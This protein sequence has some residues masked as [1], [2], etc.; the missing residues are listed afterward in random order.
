[1]FL[2][3]VIKRSLWYTFSNLMAYVQQSYHHQMLRCTIVHS[4]AVA[5]V[6]SVNFDKIVRFAFAL[7]KNFIWI[8]MLQQRM[9]NSIFGVPWAKKRHRAFTVARHSNILSFVVVV[10]NA[11]QQTN[12]F[13]LIHSIFRNLFSNEKLSFWNYFTL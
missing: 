3:D 10:K 1:M 5:L 2:Y 12:N 8:S 11:M 7:N 4:V 9:F 6:C 13:N